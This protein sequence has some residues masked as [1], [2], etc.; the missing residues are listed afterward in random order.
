MNQVKS[1]KEAIEVAIEKSKK[2]KEAILKANWNAVVGELSKKTR[3]VYVKDQIAYII[4]DGPIFLQH[5]R[6]SKEDIIKKANKLLKVEYLIDLKFK[7][8][9]V[10]LDTFF[11][12]K[13]NEEEKEIEINLSKDEIKDINASLSELNGDIREKLLKLK[14]ESLKRDKYLRAKGYKRCKQC[15][16]YFLGKSSRCV[17]CKNKSMKIVEKKLLKSFEENL[18]YTYEDAKKTYEDID[19]ERYNKVKGIKLDNLYKRAKILLYSDREKDA[20]YCLYDYFR[21]ETNTRN[22]RELEEKSNNLL[23]LMEDE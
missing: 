15:G 8:G 16:S 7:V 21:L 5:M 6:M 23:K 11:L 13:L 18:Y 20:R 9:R 19:I 17:V 1:V 14:V 2:L 3:L 4:V 12:E 22:A 10:D